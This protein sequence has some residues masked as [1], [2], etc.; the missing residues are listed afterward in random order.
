MY[1]FNWLWIF[2]LLP[3]PLLVYWLSKPA[4]LMQQQ[5]LRV[6]FYQQVEH[7]SARY[8]S[9]TRHSFSPLLGLAFIAWFF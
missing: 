6:P 3:L 7:L 4:A 1:S 8:N 5:A 2:L 9:Q